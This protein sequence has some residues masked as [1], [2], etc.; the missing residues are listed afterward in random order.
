[1]AADARGRGAGCFNEAR[2]LMLGK[3]FAKSDTPSCTECFNEARALMLG[4]SAAAP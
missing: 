4:K 1:M 2:A 3:S